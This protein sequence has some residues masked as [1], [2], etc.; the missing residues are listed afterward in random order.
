MISSPVRAPIPCTSIRS[1][2][3]A[4]FR[5]SFCRSEPAAVFRGFAYG[6]L[7]A[8][9]RAA[10]S[11]SKPATGKYTSPRT[12]TCSGCGASPGPPPASVCGTPW[13]VRTFSVTSSPVR[14]SPRV[15]ARTS[16]PRS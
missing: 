15:A 14:P 4:V 11:S 9:T 16:R 5:G 1:G 6:A 10:F 3:A 2:R 7:P 8:A 13:M 12:S